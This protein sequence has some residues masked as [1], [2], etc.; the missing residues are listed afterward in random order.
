MN[1]LIAKY[2]EG[3]SLTPDEITLLRSSVTRET[4]EA[5]ATRNSGRRGGSRRYYKLINLLFLNNRRGKSKPPKT[6]TATMFEKFR[7]LKASHNPK[8]VSGG[9]ANS[10]GNRR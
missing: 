9:G 8:I 6:Q 10:T 1:E 2:V 4:L 7:T 5:L 3:G